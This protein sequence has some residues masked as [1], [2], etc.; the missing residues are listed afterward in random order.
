MSTLNRDTAEA[1]FAPFRNAGFAL[2]HLHPRS[3]RPIGNEWSTAPVASLDDLIQTYQPGNN[4]GV[5]LGTPSRL[6]DGSYL[7]LIDVDVRDPEHAD[8]A[9]ARLYELFDGIDLKSFPTVISGSGGASRH[10]YFVTSRPFYSRK[11]IVSEGKFRGEDGKWHYTFECELF[12]T[13][14]HAVVPPS[15]HPDTGN[16]YTWEREFDFDLLAMGVGPSIAADRLEKIAT[17]ESQVYEFETREPLTFK[18]GQLEQELSEIPDER[19]DEYNSWVTLGAAL[20]HQSGGSQEGYKLWVQHSKRSAKFNEREMPAKWRSFGRNRRVPVTLATVR[21]WIL[22]ARHENML[23]Q[24]DDVDDFDDSPPALAA[25][26]AETDPLDDL[27]GT[28]AAPVD[29]IDSLI[30]GAVSNTS[31]ELDWK[32]LLDVTEKGVIK[33]TMPNITLIVMNDPRLAGVPQLNEFTQET[34]LRKAPNS[35]AP[36][37]KNAAKPTLQLEGRIWQVNDP[38]NGELWSDDR[39][40]AVR[41]AIEAPRTQGGYEIRVADRDLKAAIVIAANNSPFHPVREYLESVNWD[42]VPRAETLFID[43][44]ASE[45]NP[46]HRDTARLMLVAA[47]CRIYEPGHKFDSAIIFESL[48]GKKKSTMIEILARSWYATLDGDFANE[49]FMIEQ[50]Q[51]AWLVEMAELTGMSKSDVNAVKAFISRKKDRARLAYARR[52]GEF[53]RQCVLLGSTNQRKYLRDQTGGRR[54]W[55]I[56]C[57]RSNIDTDLLETNIDQI[58]AEAVQIYRQM[59]IDQ[60]SGTLPLYLQGEAG[61]YALMMQETRRIETTEDMMQG[62]IEAWLEK[63]ISEGG[64]EDLDEVGEP[65]YRTETC[66]AEIFVE[67]LGWPRDK[68]GRSEQQTVHNAMEQITSW[69]KT[70]EKKNF[71]PLIGRQAVYR[72]KEEFSGTT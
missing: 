4:L 33:N 66:L 24:F 8:E 52:A 62:R 27:L 63:P 6:T 43:Y 72:K 15:I 56:E 65:K 59:R 46:Y 1:L 70:S 2:H 26:S 25:D 7:H 68:Y 34:V 71:G 17:A 9:W 53:P 32:S 36:H 61:K 21:Q 35:K 37:R 11:L 23:A 54:F 57:R 19:I 29:D 44:L 14:K 38:I 3:K 30:D 13:N 18:P 69:Y 50:L 42:G 12:G 41:R 16:P 47:V 67:C 31:S 48:Q 55:P 64:F 45:D 60:P 20:H 51:G 40:F 10:I 22:D 5:R 28:P 58:W 39:D 49:K